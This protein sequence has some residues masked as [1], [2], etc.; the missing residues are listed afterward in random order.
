VT[1]DARIST[2]FRVSIVVALIAVQAAALLAMGRVPM[3]TCGTIKLWQ[4][5]VQS[6]ENSQQVLDWYSF[7]HVIHGFGFYLLTWLVAPRA[8]VL[9]R[10]ALAVSVEAAWEIFENSS[11]IIER[12]R[13]ETISLDY[14]GDSVVNSVSDTLCM[15]FG[16]A[17]ARWLPVWS[18]VTLAVLMEAFVGYMIR[19]NLTLNMIM[20]I[21]PFEAIRTWQEHGS[22]F[23]H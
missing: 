1:A 19:D 15:I 12:Y 18:I 4:G 21:Y 3:C 20:L 23:S 6:S 22:A 7:S 8:P 2:R 14:Y 9:L 11:F 10:L 13:A 5:V 16:F 17:L